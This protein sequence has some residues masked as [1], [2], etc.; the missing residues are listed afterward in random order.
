MSDV[1]IMTIFKIDMVNG[2]ERQVC[3]ISDLNEHIAWGNLNKGYTNRERKKNKLIE[4][5]V[6]FIS[7]TRV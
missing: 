7:V 4:K 5:N 2:K 6:V 3:K 1:Y